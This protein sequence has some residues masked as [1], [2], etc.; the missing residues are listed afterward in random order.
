MTIQPP[1]PRPCASCPYR[2]DVPSGIWS[3]EDYEKLPRFDG[4]TS[5]QPPGLFLCHQH[6]RNDDR[7]RVCGGW[8]GCHDSDELL[9][10]RVAPI[11]GDITAETAE[12]VRHYISPVPLFSS[13][14]EAAAHGMRDILDPGP[15]AHRAMDKITRTRTGLT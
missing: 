3:Q 13:G 6:D 10:L 14:A 11:M 7:A 12:A 2:M 5:T 9:A 15:D 4:P 1:A 8:A